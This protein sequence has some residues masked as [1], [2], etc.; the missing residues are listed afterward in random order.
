VVAIA[1]LSP[2][3]VAYPLCLPQSYRSTIL[4]A[5]FFSHDS[6][7]FFVPL[8]LNVGMACG[9]SCMLLDMEK[10]LGSSIE[11]DRDNVPMCLVKLLSI[12][13]FT[14][15]QNQ[16]NNYFSSLVIKLFL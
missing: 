10:L 6:S 2:H 8:S 16:H 13:S 15:K 1:S 3:N 5:K 9:F 4:V 7:Q 14:Q 12:S 11:A